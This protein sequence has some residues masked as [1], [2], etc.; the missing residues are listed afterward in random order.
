[1]SGKL[2]KMAGKH[3][4]KAAIYAAAGAA[5]QAKGKLWK[6]KDGKRTS[7]AGMVKKRIGIKKRKADPAK[8]AKR[9]DFKGVSM[10]KK[11]LKGDF[12]VDSSDVSH[13][14][15]KTEGNH[16]K[17]RRDDYMKKTVS[18]FK[19]ARIAASKKVNEA[20]R[21]RS[22]RASR[23][24]VFVGNFPTADRHFGKTNKEIAALESAAAAPK[25]KKKKKTA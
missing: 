19:I 17:R 24:D 8:A 15:S 4:N 23:S 1:M 3:S 25:I 7:S 13:I 10:Y 11:A 22:L 9:K 14:K 21:E 5:M 6:S 18:D 12:G 16:F 20:G 2:K